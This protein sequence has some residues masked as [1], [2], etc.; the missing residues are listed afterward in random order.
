MLSDAAPLLE[1]ERH[2]FFAAGPENFSHPLNVHWSRVRAGLSY[3][4][5]NRLGEPLIS[6]LPAGKKSVNLSPKHRKRVCVVGGVFL[7][8]M[9]LHPELVVTRRFQV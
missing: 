4:N 2:L 8:G 7:P 5:F 9:K 1:K 3:Q 6:G